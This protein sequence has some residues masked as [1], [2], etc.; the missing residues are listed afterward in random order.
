MCTSEVQAAVGVPP[1]RYAV[2]L[3]LEDSVGSTVVK[4]TAFTVEAY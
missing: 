1:G 2:S 3:R 4:Q